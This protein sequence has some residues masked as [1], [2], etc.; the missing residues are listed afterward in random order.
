MGLVKTE[1]FTDLQN[2]IALFAKAFAHPARVAILQ[3]LFKTNGCI[4]GIWCMRLAW[5]NL[6]FLNT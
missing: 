5:H 3:Q 1:I 4:C 2:E 6:R